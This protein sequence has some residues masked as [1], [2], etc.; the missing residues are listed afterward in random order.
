MQQTKAQIM[1]RQ[2]KTT[3]VNMLDDG[4]K[5][6]K[7]RREFDRHREAMIDEMH[8]GGPPMMQEIHHNQTRVTDH[9]RQANKAQGDQN[10]VLLHDQRL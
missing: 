7:D 1:K 2:Q 3:T 4:V 10:L 8:K 9:T 6:L 5:I